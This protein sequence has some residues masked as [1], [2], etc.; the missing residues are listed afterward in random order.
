L[1]DLSFSILEARYW[2]LEA[3]YSILNFAVSDVKDRR[4]GTEYL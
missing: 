1:K 4:S 2:I 3:R